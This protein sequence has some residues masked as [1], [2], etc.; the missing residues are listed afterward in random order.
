M[1]DEGSYTTKL[2]SCESLFLSSLQR[3][4]WIISSDATRG[5][6]QE[7]NGAEGGPL[8]TAGVCKSGPKNSYRLFHKHTI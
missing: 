6:S 4:K 3:H 7:E 8:D 5:L 1:S 2:P